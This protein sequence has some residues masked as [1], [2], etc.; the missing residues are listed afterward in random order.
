MKD[1]HKQR[2]ECSLRNVLMLSYSKTR[3]V[4]SVIKSEVNH[5]NEGQYDFDIDGNVVD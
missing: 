1:F 4:Q 2:Q 3:H 5:I